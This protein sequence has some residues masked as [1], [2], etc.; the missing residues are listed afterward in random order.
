MENYN[1]L[2]IENKWQSFFEKKKFLKPKRSWGKNF[3]A[4]KCFLIRQ[5]TSIWVMFEITP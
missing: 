4:L 2:V 5:E 3:I 1:P